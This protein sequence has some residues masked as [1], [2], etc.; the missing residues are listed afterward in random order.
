[1]RNSQRFLAVGVLSTFGLAIAGGFFA[2]RPGQPGLPAPPALLPAAHASPAEVGIQ[3]TLHAGET[4]SALLARAKLAEADAQ[5]LLETLRE[6]QDPRRLRAGSVVSYRLSTESGAVRGVE[7][8]LDADRTLSLEHEG[9]AWSGSVK[10]VPVHA[11]T[12]TLAGAVRTSLYASL[13][14]ADGEGVAP[15]E[16]EKIA[17]VLADRIFAW[18][19]D[20]ARDIQPGD[21]YRILYE[22]MVRP[23]GTARSGRVLGVQ[24]SIHDRDYEAYLFRSPDGAEDYYERDG[25]SLKRAFLRAPLEFRRISSVFSK[26]R[27]HPLLRTTRPHYGIDYAASA[28]TPVHSVGDG[29]VVRVGRAGGYGNLVEIRHSHGYTTRYGHLRSFAKSLRRGMRVKQGDVI[30]YV[31][32]TGL[33][34][35]PHLHYE[36]RIDGRPVDPKT[37]K[38]ITGDPVERRYRSA[39]RQTVHAQIAALDRGSEPVLLADL[40]SGAPK[41][42]EE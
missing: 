28:G 2:S 26:S 41:A 25:G 3:D 5:A 12:V 27:H 36:F 10:T 29:V 15:A 32:M 31:G 8:R 1:M 34:T 14:D 20:F 21:H 39:F 35:G 40:G 18:Q 22:R 23:D 24:F 38:F 33:A 37:V 7:F 30:G 13:L 6:H 11:D 16:R 9:E 4:L 19:V 42:G 17:D